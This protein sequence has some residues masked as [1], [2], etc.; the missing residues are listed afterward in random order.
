MDVSTD[1][2]GAIDSLYV[3]FFDKYFPRLGAEVLNFWLADDFSPSQL[4]DLFIQ[5]THI[6]L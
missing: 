5:L 4:F 6:K 3:A 2:D 1:G